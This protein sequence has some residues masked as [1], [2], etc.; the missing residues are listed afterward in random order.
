VLEE[1][2][3]AG[4]TGLLVRRADVIPEVDGHPRQP[5]VLAEDDIEAVG[6]R[7]LLE[8]QPRHVR[9]ARTLLC[10]RRHDGR[11]HERESE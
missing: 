2:R 6:Q 5:L 4:A 11:C 10:D 9:A 1:V 8:R 3:E 7:V